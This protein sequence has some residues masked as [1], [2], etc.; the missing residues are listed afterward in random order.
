MN[1]SVIH[2]SV[3]I[4]FL[5]L[6]FLSFY[7]HNCNVSENTVYKIRSNDSKKWKSLFKINHYR[8]VKQERLE[9]HIYEKLLSIFLCS[10]TM[11]KMRKLILQKK[12]N[13]RT[14]HSK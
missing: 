11:F 9:Y 13:K 2:Y 5:I 10:S 8:N 7:L 4:I 1:V 3:K 6:N 12:Q 14:C